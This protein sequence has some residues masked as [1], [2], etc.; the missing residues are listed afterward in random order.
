MMARL[1]ALT[2]SIRPTVRRVTEMP[3]TPA[4]TTNR[5]TPNASAM[6]M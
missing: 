3:A 5:V 6:S 2:D 4:S 1:V